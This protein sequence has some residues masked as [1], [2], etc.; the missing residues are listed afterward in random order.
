MIDT[1]TDLSVPPVSTSTTGA[2]RD[3]AT[4][5]FLFVFLDGVGLGAADPTRNPLVSTTL[6]G[7]WRLSG[8][9]RWTS[10]R[11]ASGG[12]GDVCLRALD[13][14]MRVR[15]LPQSGTGQASLFTGINCARLAGR[16]YG[17]YPHSQTRAAIRESNVFTQ[18]LSR[19]GSVAFANAFPPAF[20]EQAR[21]RDRWSVT[22]RCCLDAG[23]RVRSTSEIAQGTAVPADL[24]GLGLARRDPAVAAQSESDSARS[25]AVIA[26]NHSFTLFEYFLT[27]E[28][29]HRQDMEHAQTVLRSLD[30]F[31]LQLGRVLDFERTTLVVTSD[32]GNIEDLST[33]SHTQNPVPLM[34]R[35]WAANAFAGAS[36]LTD[37]TPAIV[38]SLGSLGAAAPGARGVS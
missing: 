17:P 27:D 32:H 9:A 1:P 19:G 10:T 35:G 36:S 38:A 29:G 33:R 23:V 2:A 6:F 20:F 3:R 11:F 15:G 16:H 26:G 4:H 28:A 8:A 30:Q 18:V 12:R 5:G 37:V 7:L 14:R 31:F 21:R 25:L 24:T 13:A 34:A 22:T